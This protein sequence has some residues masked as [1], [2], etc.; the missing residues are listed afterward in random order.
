MRRR[1]SSSNSFISY[2]KRERERGKETYIYE[3]NE[4]TPNA[5]RPLSLLRHE[6]NEQTP[7]PVPEQLLPLFPDPEDLALEQRLSA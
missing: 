1:V 6:K 7:D 3:L 4:R 5:N 2:A